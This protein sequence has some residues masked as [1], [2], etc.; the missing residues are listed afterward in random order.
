MTVNSKSSI[1]SDADAEQLFQNTK[2]ADPFPDIPPALL[3]SADIHDYIEATGMIFPYDSSK[4]KSSSFEMD[5]GDTAIYWDEDGKRHE[6]SLKEGEP[7]FLKPNALVFFKVA[8][9]FRLPDYMAIR[10]NLRITNVHRGLLLG[11]GP[12]V[13]PGFEG[14][15]LIP[16]HNLTN[17]P[18]TFTVG[19]PFIWVEFTKISPN[20]RWQDN[21]A[22]EP[23]RTGQYT[24]F[25]DNKKNIPVAQYLVKAEPHRSIQNAIPVALDTAR[26]DAAMA[27]EQAKK[28]QTKTERNIKTIEW[29]GFIAVLAVVAAF[30]SL[31]YDSVGLSSNASKMIADFQSEYQD[32]LSSENLQQTKIATIEKQI[33]DKIIG[34]KSKQQ[35]QLDQMK[36]QLEALQLELRNLKAQAMKPVP[37]PEKAN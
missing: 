33:A 15:L 14:H 23:E 29:G 18:Y 16:L 5:I 3:N 36:K 6:R 22:Q 4:L 8:Q 24:P 26:K 19:E 13:D 11:T 20:L 27:L 28:F 32:H 31:V 37:I 30:F 7:V 9:K 35:F 21:P 34:S 2:N 1:L 12:L 25:P 17:N 10:F